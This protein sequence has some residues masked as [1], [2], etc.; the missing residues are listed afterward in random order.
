MPPSMTTDTHRLR[1]RRPPPTRPLPRTPAQATRQL[2]R[3]QAMATPPT[4]HPHLTP[5]RQTA[6]WVPLP[7]PPMPTLRRLPTPHP[8]PAHIRGATPRCSAALKRQARQA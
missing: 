4:R 6:G 3:R 2:H 8:R 7:R 1:R 5:R